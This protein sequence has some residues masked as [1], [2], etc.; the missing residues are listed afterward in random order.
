MRLLLDA[1]KMTDCKPIIVFSGTSTQCGIPKM[2]PVDENVIDNPITVYDFHKLQ[3][4]NWIKFYTNQGWVQGTSMRLTN[5]Y[6]PGPISS[7]PD[8]GILNLMI[9][10]ALNG[11]RLVIY[12]EGDYIR[13]Y[14]FINDVVET[15]LL[16]PIYINSMIGRHFILG[17]GLGVT[18]SDAIKLVGKIV[19]KETNLKIEIDRVE[20]PSIMGKI[21]SRNFTADLSSLRKLGLCK[22][23]CDLDHGIQK[24]VQFYN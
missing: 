4:E 20:M 11:E 5:V 9:K 10:K 14:I 7:S 1:C 6:G 12:G 23:M 3:A 2:L 24:T 22:K 8:R 13:D 15:F 18:I 19:S 17:S 16:I 21:E